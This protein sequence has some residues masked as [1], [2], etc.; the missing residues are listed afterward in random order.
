MIGH[1]GNSAETVHGESADGMK[2]ALIL[3][4][5]LVDFEH[6]LEP[7]QTDRAIDKQRAVF[8]SDHIAVGGRVV[9]RQ[10]ANDRGQ[11]IGERHQALQVAILIDDQPELN[12]FA[13][14]AFQQLRGADGLGQI[15]RRT[16]M[17]LDLQRLALQ[18]RAQQI[19]QTQHAQ[20]MLE[21]TPAHNDPG[22]LTFSDLGAY[23]RVA[24]LQ[25]DGIDIHPRRHDCA[26]SLIV[27]AQHVRDDR[28]LAL[29]KDAGLGA[30][31]HQDLDLV[32]GNRWFTGAACTK[33]SQQNVARR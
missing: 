6:C 31:S 21:S 12:P 33:Q 10:V 14:K 7:L 28:L 23:R 19:D 20:D 15:E 32:V 3:G 9:L 29:M 1:R 25:I 27:K 17:P 18:R 8:A 24:V 26:D 5:Q 22:M 4:R 2:T 13:A 30:L 16:Q 11:H